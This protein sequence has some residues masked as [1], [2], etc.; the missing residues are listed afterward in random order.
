MYFPHSSQHYHPCQNVISTL[1][2][3][4]WLDITKIYPIRIWMLHKSV[5]KDQVCGDRNL[6]WC[7]LM[8]SRKYILKVLSNKYRIELKPGSDSSKLGN[9]LTTSIITNDY[10][11]IHI[12]VFN[13]FLSIS[14]HINVEGESILRPEKI[15][16]PYSSAWK[17]L[18]LKTAAFSKRRSLGRSVMSIST[19][20]YTLK[21]LWKNTTIIHLYSRLFRRTI[22]FVLSEYIGCAVNFSKRRL[23]FAILQI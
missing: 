8:F 7:V 15:P 2:V 1:P 13:K 16:L 20:I 12:E 5:R 22:K 10:L 14:Q 9:V 18:S 21:L 23:L 3:Y 17:L 11:L 19:E 4:T 6:Q